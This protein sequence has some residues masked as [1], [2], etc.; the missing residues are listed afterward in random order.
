MTEIFEIPYLCFAEFGMKTLMIEH[1]HAVGN[2][3]FF[4]LCRN[5]RI[6]ADSV[7]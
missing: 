7:L 4:F 6:A 5:M 2:G 1:V 3:N